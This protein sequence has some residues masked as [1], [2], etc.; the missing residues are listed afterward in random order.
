MQL[1]HHW[2]QRS[3]V[4]GANTFEKKSEKKKSHQKFINKN[5][6]SVRGGER[7]GEVNVSM[8]LFYKGWIEYIIKK[9]HILTL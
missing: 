6:A 9:M 5:E 8:E 4:G 7:R 2:L 3:S 1:F